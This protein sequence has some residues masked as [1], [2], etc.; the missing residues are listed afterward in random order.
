MLRQRIDRRLK[1]TIILAGL[2]S[3]GAWSAALVFAPR[4]SMEW[5]EEMLSA[6]RTMTE[7]VAVIGAERAD[8]IPAADPNATGLIG[9]EYGDLHT[10]LGDLEAKRTTTGPDLAALLVHL[11]RSA[12]VEEGDT[13]AVGCSAS[14]PALMIAVVAAA[15]AMRVVPVVI[16]SLG[17]SSWGATD[18]DFNLLD[19]H[20]LLVDEG[21][22]DT[23]PVAVS[24]GGNRDTGS[25]F[26]PE[27]R[28]RLIGQVMASGLPFISADDLTANVAARLCFYLGGGEGGDDSN[29]AAFVN[30]GG[31]YANMGTSPLILDL[32]PGLNRG[33]SLPERERRGVVF[34]MA[35]RDIPIVHL[36]HIRG[37]ALRYGL[38]WDPMPLPEI[39]TTRF[40]DAR[41]GDHPLF[42]VIAGLYLLALAATVR[43]GMRRPSDRDIQE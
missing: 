26:E 12:G 18:S 24:L 27:V 39:G 16:I 41:S 23:L 21:V 20:E 11:L 32:D 9:P 6:A 10:S 14:F 38:P 7:A 37:L 28:Q 36:L 13:I 1:H 5:T 29:I 34:E 19:I 25:D 35:A 22:I 43:F 8:R 31:A 3:L 17:A 40:H 33:M 15:E 30:T 2:V 4:R 42:P